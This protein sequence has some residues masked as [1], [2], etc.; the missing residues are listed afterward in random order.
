MIQI[1]V[2]KSDKLYDIN[3]TLQDADGAAFNLI[4]ISTLL[5]KVQ[6]Q[7]AATLKFSGG[8]EVVNATSGTCKYT[9]QATNFDEVGHYYAEIE[10]TFD[11]GK[12]ITFGDIV[13][14]VQP[15]LP[16]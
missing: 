4:G 13:V 8:M 11:D 3:F 1:R 6:R 16:R 12:V 9:A 5:F 7:E 15:E 10:A 14:I 2:F